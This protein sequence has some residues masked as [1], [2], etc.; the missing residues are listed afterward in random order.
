MHHFTTQETHVN[1]YVFFSENYFVGY[2][3]IGHVL[4][5]YFA[6]VFITHSKQSP[7]KWWEGNSELFHSLMHLW[8]VW[9]FFLQK[10]KFQKIIRQTTISRHYLRLCINIFWPDKRAKNLR[11]NL[12]NRYPTN[13]IIVWVHKWKMFASS[14][15]KFRNNFKIPDF[16]L[17]SAIFVFYFESFE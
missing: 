9:F 15:N 16:C 8:N 6:H 14:T 13:L 7:L 3:E 12:E 17:F 4:F 11:V 1:E 10:N 2:T 5:V